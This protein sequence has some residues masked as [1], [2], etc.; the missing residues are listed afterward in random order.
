MS[1]TK[2]IDDDI[3]TAMRARDKD[4]LSTLRMVKTAFKN[5]EIEA[6][7]PIDEDTAVDVLIRLTKQRKDSI[8]QFEKAG[9][10]DLADVEK[11]ELAFIEEYLPSAPD[12]AEMKEAAQAVIADLGANS[13]KQMG[14]VMSALK[15]KFAGRPVDGKAMSGLVKSLLGS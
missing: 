6:R 4:R 5:K 10:N 11:R 15:E 8:E 14:A 9:R 7:E 2:R 13:M 3:K 12:E 1:L